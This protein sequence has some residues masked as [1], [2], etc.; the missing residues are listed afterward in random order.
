MK[1]YQN[2]GTNC[3]LLAI[4]INICYYSNKA[5]FIPQYLINSLHKQTIQL[6]TPRSLVSPLSHTLARVKSPCLQCVSWTLIWF[7]PC[8]AN[9]QII[10]GWCLLIMSSSSHVFQ[11]STTSHG[12]IVEGRFNYKYTYACVACVPSLFMNC[13]RTKSLHVA[14]VA[15]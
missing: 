12:A 6:V 5:Y 8:L 4:I 11:F 10:Y 3:I 2:L 9:R 1:V 13:L 14:L 7:R 15:D